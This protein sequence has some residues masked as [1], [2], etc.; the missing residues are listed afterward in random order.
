M[1]TTIKTNIK[2]DG[3]IEIEKYIEKYININKNIAMGS[4]HILVIRNDNTLWA[5][6]DNYY[7]QLGT[8]DN[9]DREEFVKVLEDV[10]FVEAKED[11]SFAIKKDGTLWA[12]GYNYSG[13]LGTGDTNNRNIWTKVLDD[14]IY[15]EPQNYDSYAIKKD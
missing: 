7:G 12:T 11:S 4:D 8:G 2:A 15:V 6:G 1:T 14:V 10:V 13:Q 5:I 9:K 3:N